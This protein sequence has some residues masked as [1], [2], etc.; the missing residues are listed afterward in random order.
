MKQEEKIKNYSWSEP[1][2]SLGFPQP[3]QNL[4]KEYQAELAEELAEYFPNYDKI[5]IDGADGRLW[6]SVSGVKP[7]LGKYLE[8][9]YDASDIEGETLH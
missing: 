4:A 5:E 1:L 3:W 7:E 2:N 9:N 8:D 6:I